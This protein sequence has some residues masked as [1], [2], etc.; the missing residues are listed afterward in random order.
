MQGQVTFGFLNGSCRIRVCI[1]YKNTSDPAQLHAH[2]HF[3]LSKLRLWVGAQPANG[4]S[5]QSS[6]AEMDTEQ[7]D[8]PA[9][10]TPPS[11]SILARRLLPPAMNTSPWKHRRSHRDTG[12]QH[13]RL[14]RDS[15]AKLGSA[16]FTIH[17]HTHTQTAHI[18]I[19]HNF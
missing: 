19:M 1:T 2:S 14:S 5:Q 7:T 13:V 10:T 4:H 11:S 3:R 8:S 9:H 16:L 17:T 18:H 15:K 12:P 6:R